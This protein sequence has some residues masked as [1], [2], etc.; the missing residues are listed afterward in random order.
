MAHWGRPGDPRFAGW[1][2]SLI[3]R[4]QETLTA[5][6]IANAEK[7]ETHGRLNDKNRDGGFWDQHGCGDRGGDEGGSGHSWG[8]FIAERT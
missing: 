8:S 7:A 6:V 1:N 2:R 4:S 3:N 5:Q